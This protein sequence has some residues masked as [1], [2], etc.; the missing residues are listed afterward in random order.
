MSDITG[1]KQAIV[2]YFDA[3]NRGDG[4]AIAAM[5]APGGIHIVT[6]NT[7]I[8]GTYSGQQM[9]E[10]AGGLMR[11]FPAGLEFELGEMVAEGNKVCFE[12]ESRGTHYS[13]MSYNNFYMWIVEFKDGL[14]AE[15]KEYFDTEQTRAVLCGGQQSA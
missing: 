13:G 11:A 5:Y 12:V 14:I 1:N 10:V 8:S 4:A 9:A 7:P 6:G 15:S 2:R 3:C